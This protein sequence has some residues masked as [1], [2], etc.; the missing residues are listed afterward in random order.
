MNEDVKKAILVAIDALESCREGWTYEGDYEVYV[1]DFDDDKVQ[2][3]L[4]A[5]QALSWEE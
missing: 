2:A 5:L 1:R 3:A 4:T